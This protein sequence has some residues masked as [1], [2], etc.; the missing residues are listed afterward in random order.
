M[1]VKL[2][3]LDVVLGLSSSSKYSH[4][5]LK[6]WSLMVRSPDTKREMVL[7]V[8]PVFRE[9]SLWLLLQLRMAL[10]N[11]SLTFTRDTMTFLTL[12]D[13]NWHHQ[14]IWFALLMQVI[15]PIK[16][17]KNAPYP[18]DF[19]CPRD[20]HLCSLSSHHEV[21]LCYLVSGVKRHDSWPVQTGFSTNYH[22]LLLAP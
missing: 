20:L 5:S 15:L 1:F 9:I 21:G 18:L 4:K 11:C 2:Q 17:L 8:I 22:S 19:S 3:S 13:A 10:I 6:I 7:D 14:S 12:S 16:C